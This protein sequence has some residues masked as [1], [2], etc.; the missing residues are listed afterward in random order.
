MPCCPGLGGIYQSRSP[1][2]VSQSGS[3]YQSRSHALLS[4]SGSTYQ[5]RS[6]ALLSRSGGTYQSR[7]PALV[8]QSGS[9]Y[10]SRSHALLSRS[11]RHLSEQIFCLA[12]P[13]NTFS[14]LLFLH[15][16]YQLFDHS[17]SIHIVFSFILSNKLID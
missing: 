14:F 5:S 3:T 6:H 2:L 10:Q 7:S 11:G 17:S 8:S 1:A 16:Y 15:T 9:T 4:R 13:F 12:V